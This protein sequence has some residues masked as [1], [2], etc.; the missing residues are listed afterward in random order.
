MG[1]GRGVDFTP[2]LISKVQVS[3]A[4]CKITAINQAVNLGV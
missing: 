3:R 4:F 2:L 1:K